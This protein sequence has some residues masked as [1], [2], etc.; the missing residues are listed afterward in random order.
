MSGQWHGGKGSRARPLVVPLEQFNANMDR[1]FG[2]KE[3]ERIAKAK[4]RAEYFTKLEA[5]TKARLAEANK[6]KN[7]IAD[8]A[9][10]DAYNEERLVSKF[11]K[12]QLAI[13]EISKLVAEETLQATEPKAEDNK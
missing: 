5:E 8:P 4:E 12:Q 6:K 3:E 1:I 11:D 13:N 7:E 2:S 10:L 9:A